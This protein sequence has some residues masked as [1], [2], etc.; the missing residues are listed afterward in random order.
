MKKGANQ[1]GA[2]LS[3]TPLAGRPTQ[4]ARAHL[5]TR[6][7]VVPKHVPLRPRGVSRPSHQHSKREYTWTEGDTSEGCHLID[8]REK[9]GHIIDR[10]GGENHLSCHNRLQELIPDIGVERRCIKRARA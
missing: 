5:A 3:V 7:G 6:P 2:D 9:T 10:S 8:P 1:G 4:A